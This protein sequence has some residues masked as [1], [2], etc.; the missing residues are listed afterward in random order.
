MNNKNVKN[1]YDKMSQNIT[2]ASE[3]RNKAKDFSKYDIEF[4]KSIS[5]KEK[6]LLDLGS[7][8]GLLINHLIDNFKEIIAVEKYKNFSNF[9]KESKKIKIIND[10][11]LSLDMKINCCDIVSLFGVMNCFNLEESRVIYRNTFDYLR[12]NGM[13]IVKNQMGLE[14]DVIIDGFSEELQTD[15]YANYRQVDNEI[16]LLHSI[17]FKYIEKIDIYPNEYNRWKDTHFYALVCKK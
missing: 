2:V 7:G 14:E 15:Y 8:T 17:G 16:S 3:T 6:I 11:L 12:A 10:D 1:Y 9:I 13:L 5:D 4:M